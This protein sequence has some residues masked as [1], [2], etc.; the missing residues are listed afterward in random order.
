MEINVVRFSDDYWVIPEEETAHLDFGPREA[1]FQKPK[2]SDNHL[3]ALYVRGHIN[4]KSV[5]RM[6][7]DSRAI[8]NLMPYSLYKKLGGTDEEIIKTNMTVRG[9]GGGDPIGAKGVALMKLTVGSKTVATAF[10][11]SEVQGNFNLILGHD[12]VHA[13]QCVPSSFHQFLI[14]WIG[15]EVEVVR[16][17]TSSFVG[18]ADSELIGAHDHIKCLSGLDLTDYDLI[19][20]TKEG[21]V[22]AVLKPMENR[23]QLLL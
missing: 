15:D 3:K 9:I 14:Q 8:V 22:F 11:V 20:C 23:L 16:G 7:V 2:D 6:L 21:F 4:G 18:T 13:N 17:D 5:S 10:F 1:I 19:S 12:W